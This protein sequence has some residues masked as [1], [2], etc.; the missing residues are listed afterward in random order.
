MAQE[1]LQKASLN[2][3]ESQLRSYIPFRVIHLVPI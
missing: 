3:T 1:A 2:P